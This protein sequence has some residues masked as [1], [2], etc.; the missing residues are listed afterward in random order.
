M[1]ET[2]EYAYLFDDAIRVLFSDAVRITLQDLSVAEE[3]T[4]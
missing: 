3:A 4:T 2:T 1:S